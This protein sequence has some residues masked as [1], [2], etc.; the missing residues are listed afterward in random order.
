MIHSLKPTIFILTMIQMSSLG[1]AQQNYRIDEV[2]EWNLQAVTVRPETDG[3]VV[4]ASEEGLPYREER[5]TVKK[6]VTE[7]MVRVE[8][9]VVYKPVLV[10]NSFQPVTPAPGISIPQRR[11]QWTPGGYRVDPVSGQT[12]FQRGALRWNTNSSNALADQNP[13]PYA[14][15]YTYQ[16]EVVETRTPVTVTRY[17]DEV[18]TRRVPYQPKIAYQTI[19]KLVAVK[20]RYK[21]PINA[22]GDATGPTVR[23]V[24]PNDSPSAITASEPAPSIDEVSFRTNKNSESNLKSSTSVLK[25][26]MSS[27]TIDG[28]E[29]V[30]KT[31]T[32]PQTVKLSPTALSN[33]KET[34]PEVPTASNQVGKPSKTETNESGSTAPALESSMKSVWGK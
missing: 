20:V 15:I 9:N 33:F 12:S 31:T 32:E 13:Q 1:V 11:I 23:I 24:I 14:P 30:L 18:V 26:K 2:T 28:F 25:P 4:E 29:G 3:A 27:S 34:T 7:E 19:E 16:P 21:T 5:I 6:P 10:P 17:V 8:Q 22:T